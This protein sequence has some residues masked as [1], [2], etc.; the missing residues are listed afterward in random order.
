MLLDHPSLDPFEALVRRLLD[1]AFGDAL[2]GLAAAGLRPGDEWYTEAALV[3]RVACL[4]GFRK[5]Q[6]M[7]GAMVLELERHI[8]ALS[9]D[10]ANARRNR[11]SPP[12]IMKSL[13]ITLEN[14]QLAL[15]RLVDSFLWV[16]VLPNW[17]ILRRLRVD[18]GIKRIAPET[19]KPL[20][21]ALA[22]RDERD[23]SVSISCD[24]TTTAQL[25]D[26][27]IAMWIPSRNVMKI[28]VA[29]LKVGS[30]NILL[31]ERL[32]RTDTS[33]AQDKIAQIS[34]ELG[35]KAALQAERML[36]QERRLKNFDRVI[37]TD[38]GADPMSGRPFKMTR[39]TTIFKDYRDKLSVILA[40]AKT[41]GWA[42]VTLD[43]CLH[44]IAQVPTDISVGSKGL[45]IAHDFYHLRH[46][47]FCG[48]NGLDVDKDTEAMA[49]KNAPLAVNLFDFCMTQSLAMPPFLWF[50]QDL[51]MDALCGRIE[52]FTQLDYEE[53]FEL[54]KKWAN[55][56]L[57]FVTGK[58]ARRI[59]VSKISA[60]LMEYRDKRFV[61]AKRPGHASMM[62]GAR[63][64]GDLYLSLKRPRD[65]LR[66]L[67]S[68]MDQ[69]A[70]DQSGAGSAPG[71][72]LP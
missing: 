72:S 10:E 32:G 61:L 29:E 67:V 49:I 40:R 60:P 23:E 54:A 11:E 42:G 19:L 3:F 16:L 30:M 66:S 68:L 35:P 12:A 58:Q 8:A 38:E 52:I 6:Q 22:A 4:P 62:F 65:L 5:T 63:F 57:E 69:V 24:L 64:F 46:G 71:K 17:W 9:C 28:V 37:A 70:E 33:D 36:R 44:L 39:K 48:A 31:R 34:G 1:C 7:I 27:I 21:D 56:D 53:F 14:R 2:R 50:P 41:N 20:L 18:G 45:K 13:K 15:R 26:L 59:A 25:G 55:I 51:M 43:R 47:S